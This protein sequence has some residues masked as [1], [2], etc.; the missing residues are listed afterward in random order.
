VKSD[1]PVDDEWGPA[2]GK[3]CQARSARAIV[4]SRHR[5]SCDLPPSTAPRNNPAAAQFDPRAR[6]RSSVSRRKPQTDP[7]HPPTLKASEKV[8]GK[9]TPRSIAHQLA[10]GIGETFHKVVEDTE[11]QFYA[12]DGPLMVVLRKLPLHS[13]YSIIECVT[14]LQRTAGKVNGRIVSLVTAGVVD[15][16]VR[17]RVGFATEFYAVSALYTTLAG[18]SDE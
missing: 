16:S 3:F 7:L 13:T 12:S 9:P 8:I 6:S 17:D 5:R 15:V 18:L 1:E 11:V 2:A 14:F 10:V 4:A